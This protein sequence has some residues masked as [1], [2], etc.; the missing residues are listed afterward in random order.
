MV[1]EPK[2]RE[3]INGLQ[4]VPSF[5]NLEMGGL[6]G[7]EAAIRREEEEAKREIPKCNPYDEKQEKDANSIDIN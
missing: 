2:Q 3:Q 4:K 7:L 5:E 1:S 6:A